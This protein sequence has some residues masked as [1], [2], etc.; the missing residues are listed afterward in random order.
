MIRELAARHETIA[1][2]ETSTEGVLAHW[3]AAA[4]DA[5]T[6]QAF[7]GGVVCHSDP[8]SQRFIAGADVTSRAF[9]G[10]A[11]QRVRDE[12]QATYGLA[13]GRFPSGGPFWIGLASSDQVE[14]YERSFA[15]HPD[16][17]IERSVKQALDIV[18]RQLQSSG[19]WAEPQ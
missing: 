15:G 5:H 6:S 8:C 12:N 16:I 18:R 3:L 10:Q 7:V 1:T 13:L 4:D 14:V 19:Q 17:F 2:L 9:A 11:A